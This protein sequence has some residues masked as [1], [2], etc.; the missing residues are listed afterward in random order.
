MIITRFFFTSEA[1][2]T[3]TYLSGIV[4]WERA[5]NL[6]REVQA[7]SS[8]AL[9]RISHSVNASVSGTNSD[10]AERHRIFEYIE[11]PRVEKIDLSAYH[12]DLQGFGAGTFLRLFVLDSM[13]KQHHLTVPSPLKMLAHD[14]DAASMALNSLKQVYCQA[15]DIR[16]V[17]VN[18]DKEWR[19]I[20]PNYPRRKMDEWRARDKKSQKAVNSTDKT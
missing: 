14:T 19:F 12:K 8:L 3:D 13:R 5:V 16:P 1:W 7:C 15:L 10:K 17:V 20:Y 9:T 11:S 18:S 6:A 2:D 4:S